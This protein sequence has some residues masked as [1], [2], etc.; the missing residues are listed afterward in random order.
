MIETFAVLENPIQAHLQARAEELFRTSSMTQLPVDGIR[1][2]RPIHDLPAVDQM[3]PE[4]KS[5]C[6][7]VFLGRVGNI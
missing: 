7:V 6:L 5:Q 1:D 4:N 2:E 3:A